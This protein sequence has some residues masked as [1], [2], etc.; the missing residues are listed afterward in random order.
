M[1]YELIFRA[2]LLGLT[3]AGAGFFIWCWFAFREDWKPHAIYTTSSAS[4]T[5]R[6]KDEDRNGSLVKDRHLKI[7]A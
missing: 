4:G 5:P 6:R 1:L 2:A 3:V 7:S